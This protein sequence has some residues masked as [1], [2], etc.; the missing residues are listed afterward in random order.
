MKPRTRL[1]CDEWAEANIK[2]TL[3]AEPGPFRHARRPYFRAPHAWF[4]D[5]TITQITCRASAQVSKTTWIGNCI[6]YAI[7]EDPGPI[8]YASS[9]EKVAKTWVKTRFK[10]QVEDCDALRALKPADDDDYNNM[11]MLFKTCPVSIA[12]GQSAAG[13]ASRP[14]RYLFLDEV[15]KM[16]KATDDESDVLALFIQRTRTFRQKKKII[17]TSTPTTPKGNVNKHYLKGSQHRLF[18]ACPHCQGEFFFSF[19]E[20]FSNGGIKWPD[21]CKDDDGKW[22]LDEVAERATYLCPHCEA[23]I[24]QTHQREMVNAGEW[25]STNDKARKSHISFH[26]DTMSALPWGEVACLFLSKKDEPGGLQDFYNSD[27]GLPYERQHGG[28]NDAAITAV[29]MASPDYNAPRRESQ[30]G[31][32]K[33][34][35]NLAEFAPVVAITTSVDVQLASYWWST[36]LWLED[37]SSFLIDWGDAVSESDIM[38][39]GTR[40]YEFASGEIIQPYKCIIDSGYRTKNEG[41]VYLFCQRSGGLFTPSKGLGDGKGLYEPVKET[42]IATGHGDARI[43]LIQY[44]DAMLK[45]WLY[46]VTIKKQAG[47]PWYL[48][49]NL[50][51]NYRVQ[52]QDE[53]LV[54]ENGKID[55]K[56]G[57]NNHLGDTEKMNLALREL[58]ISAMVKVRKAKRDNEERAKAAESVTTK[59]GDQWSRE[60]NLR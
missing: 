47:A 19:R 56:D 20:E 39:I 54:E 27:L 18:V 40:K 30:E 59:D 25:R 53:K 28:V 13:A 37:M 41:G 26:I 23:H 42:I 38:R 9:D 52:I 5:P 49:R 7:C 3:T 50:D 22:D 11:E 34:P 58:L 24:E 4:S 17:I 8:L 44:R 48:P 45:D 16:A 60:Y 55:Y 33:V 29:Q 46:E 1:G 51:A 21:D 35:L 6:S 15:D 14:I 57:G 32:W 31:T 10:P 36:R 2:L 43:N 12:G